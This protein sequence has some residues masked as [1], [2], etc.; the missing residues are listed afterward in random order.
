MANSETATTTAVSL[1]LYILTRTSGRPLLYRRLRESIAALSYPGRVVHIVHSDCRRD[2]YVEGDCDILIRGEN[3]RNLPV[4]SRP[5]QYNLYCNRLLEV[6][7]GLPSGWVHFIDD[8]DEYAASDVFERMLEGADGTAIRVGRVHRG[9]GVYYPAHWGKQSSFQTEICVFPSSIALEG[10]W[11]ATTGG[12]HYYTRQLTRSYPLEWMED[13]LIARTIVGKGRGNRR[14]LPGEREVSTPPPGEEYLFVKALYRRD[15]GRYLP[16][17][18]ALALPERRWTVTY[19]GVSVDYLTVERP[20][21]E[22]QFEEYDDFLREMREDR[23]RLARGT[24]DVGTTVKKSPKLTTK[25]GSSSRPS[26]V[27]RR[28]PAANPPFPR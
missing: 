19:E 14:D 6:V 4:K 2:T 3:L 16:A 23:R 11:P 15:A 24:H 8:D 10:R 22:P 21:E 25:W 28:H 27:S 20:E 18:E 9:G 1:P 5:G 17:R 7:R 13:V 12:D 26:P